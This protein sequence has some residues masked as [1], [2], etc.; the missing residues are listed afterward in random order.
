[1]Q[2]YDIMNLVKKNK[3]NMDNDINI[4]ILKDTYLRFFI[5]LAINVFQYENIPNGLDVKALE[6]MLLSNNALIKKDDTNCI[7]AIPYSYEY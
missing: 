5:N 2:L 3:K 4:T 1:M 7:L 6:T